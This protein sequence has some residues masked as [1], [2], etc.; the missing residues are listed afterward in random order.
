MIVSYLNCPITKEQDAQCS[1]LLKQG[2][3]LYMQTY[4]VC[5]KI[6]VVLFAV[7]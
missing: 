4:F 5:K 3:M 7:C 2:K 1:P 6:G